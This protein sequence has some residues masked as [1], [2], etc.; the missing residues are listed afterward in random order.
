MKILEQIMDKD[1]QKFWCS[2]NKGLTVFCIY[3]KQEIN[4][5]RCP[6]TCYYAKNKG[7]LK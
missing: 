4:G 5:L 7:G 1:W 2:E 6:E 3:Y